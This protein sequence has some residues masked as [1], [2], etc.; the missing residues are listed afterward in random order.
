MFCKTFDTDRGQIVALSQCDTEADNEWQIAVLCQPI[1][2]DSHCQV[3]LGFAT[4]EKRDLMFD[5]LSEKTV[6]NLTAGLYDCFPEGEFSPE[7]YARI[8]VSQ[9]EVSQE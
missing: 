2:A 3:A 1:G 6:L 7:A 8:F 9:Q 4:R 5:R